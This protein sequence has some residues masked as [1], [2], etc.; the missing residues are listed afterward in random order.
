M[1]FSFQHQVAHP[2][3]QG[4]RRSVKPPGVVMDMNAEV[5]DSS[6]LW[7]TPE[8]SGVDPDDQEN[9]FKVVC[10]SVNDINV[11]GLA[12]FQCVK[13]DEKE[14]KKE[15]QEGRKQHLECPICFDH[16]SENAYVLGCGCQQLYC[17]SCTGEVIQRQGDAEGRMK[18]LL[19]HVNV[20]VLSLAWFKPHSKENHKEKIKASRRGYQAWKKKAKKAV[21]QAAWLQHQEVDGNVSDESLPPATPRSKKSRKHKPQQQMHQ[22]HAHSLSPE[23]PQPQP[24][25]VQGSS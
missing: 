13:H 8:H 4:V 7:V 22:S 5:Y 16:L 20:P 19:C 23:S 15:R 18:C 6:M 25:S 1:F 10:A 11:D 21:Q 2:T 3:E 9:K 14:R 12:I 17:G 24:D